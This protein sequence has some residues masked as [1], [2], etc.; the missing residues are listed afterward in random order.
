MA[1][2]QI[3]VQF[4]QQFTPN[5]KTS[6]MTMVCPF[7]TILR[8]KT[9][10][11]CLEQLRTRFFELLLQSQIVLII[12]HSES[13]P[14]KRFRGHHKKE[15]PERESL[16]LLSKP[17]GTQGDGIG[18]LVLVLQ[19]LTA[20][21]NNCIAQMKTGNSEVVQHSTRSAVYIQQQ[22]CL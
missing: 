12:D 21:R 14:E 3:G 7:A 2:E 1:T 6:R 5:T 19:Q 4:G 15:R 22:Q 20:Q 8:Y 13:L 17:L 9:A 11:W 18:V 16:F 10:I